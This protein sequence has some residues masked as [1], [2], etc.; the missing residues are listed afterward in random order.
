MVEVM[1][2]AI[3][4]VIA[5]IGTSALFVSGRKQLINQ[6]FYRAAAQLSSQKFEE[7]KAEGYDNLDE[8][9]YEENLSFNGV[10]YQRRTLTE[11]TAEPS[12]EIPKPCKRVTVT[13]R[14]SIVNDQHEA[15]LVTYIGP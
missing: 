8:G 3:I 1:I 7:C 15:R 2:A 12:A 9:E 4:L 13:I 10:A 6:Q 5:L 14:W 11:L